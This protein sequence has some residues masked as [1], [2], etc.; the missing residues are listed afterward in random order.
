[1]L[2]GSGLELKELPR[3]RGRSVLMAN[4][5]AT[6]PAPSAPQESGPQGQP[7]QLFRSES[8]FPTARRPGPVREAPRERV[9]KVLGPAGIFLVGNP[10]DRW[11]REGGW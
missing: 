9:P 6:A 11:G 1:M 7:F 5:R 2:L 3:W 8:D 4:A 10:K